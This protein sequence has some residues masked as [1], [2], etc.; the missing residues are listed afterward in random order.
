MTI[1]GTEPSAALV[2][3]KIG[4]TYAGV[5]VRKESSRLKGHTA[6]IVTNR[7]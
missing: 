3:P 6:R 5:S 4:N 1:K 7:K 2:A